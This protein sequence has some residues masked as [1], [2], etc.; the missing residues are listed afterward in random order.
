MTTNTLFASRHIGP[1]PADIRA[2][3]AAIGAPSVETLISQAVPAS[4]RLERPLDLPPAATEAEALA[5]LAAK[6][7]RQQGA[8]ELCWSGL[9]RHFHP[10]GDPAK[11]V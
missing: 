10:A 11:S 8:E 1:S 9:S 5:E 2:M 7:V 6:D 4:I 3:L